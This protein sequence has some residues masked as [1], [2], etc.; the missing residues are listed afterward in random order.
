[1]TLYAL[2]SAS[3]WLR[4]RVNVVRSPERGEVPAE[5]QFEVAPNTVTDTTELG[6]TGLRI[7]PGQ[8]WEDHV[9]A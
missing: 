7:G 1:M 8:H 6:A 5:V 3:W 9:I 4:I 2:V